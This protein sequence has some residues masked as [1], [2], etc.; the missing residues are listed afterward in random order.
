MASYTFFFSKKDIY[1]QWYPATFTLANKTFTCAEQWMMWSKA[2]LFGDK[3]VA[4][5]IM[6]T[7]DPLIHKKLGRSVKNFDCIRWNTYAR[8]IVYVGNLAK[9]TQNPSLLEQLLLTRDTT[10]AEANPRDKIWGIGLSA[11]SKNANRRELWRGT[12]WLGDTLTLLRDE[13]I[14]G[15]LDIPYDKLHIVKEEEKAMLCYLMEE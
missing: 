12:N 6:K 4:S 14:N 15:N 7:N 9:F 2:I 3:D 5:K 8:A 1:S 10:L 11:T 13:L